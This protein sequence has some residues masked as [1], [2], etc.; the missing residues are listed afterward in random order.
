[1]PRTVEEID[2]EI[3]RLKSEGVHQSA[4]PI[5]L[6]RD[7]KAAL[8]NP[9]PK[10][11]APE[12]VFTSQV[13]VCQSVSSGGGTAIWVPS[14]HNSDEWR[15]IEKACAEIQIETEGTMS[16]AVKKIYN[17]LEAKVK[18]WRLAR[19]IVEKVGVGGKWPQ[20]S[21]LN[22]NPSTGEPLPPPIPVLK[23]SMPGPVA[24]VTPSGMPV[25]AGRPGRDEI[26]ATVTGGA[27][28]RAMVAADLAQRAQPVS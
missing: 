28:P 15:F 22:I 21:A 3:A 7:E 14:P 27:D 5:R 24:D 8:L 6:L 9:T 18:M 2:A 11:Q 17:V 26:I 25:L 1:M 13:G 20:F 19:G 10:V 12:A 16:N 23:P 4:K